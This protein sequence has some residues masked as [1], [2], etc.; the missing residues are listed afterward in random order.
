MVITR[1]DLRAVATAVATVAAIAVATVAAIAVAAV[2]AA[3]LLGCSGEQPRTEV[4][5]PDPVVQPARPA[6]LRLVVMIVVDQLPSWSFDNEQRLLTGG[7]RRLIDEGVYFPRAE[8]PYVITFTAPGH[9]ALGTGAPPSQTGILANGWF[10]PEEGKIVAATADEN[11]PVFRLAGEPPKDGAPPA[12]ES[13]AQLE[14]DG[15]ADALRAGGS[16]GRSVSI[17]LKSRAAIFALGRKPDLA[18]WYDADQPAMTSSRYYADEPP[19]WLVQLAEKHPVSDELDYVWRPKNLVTLGWTTMAPDDQRGEGGDYG[20]GITFPHDIAASENPARALKNTPLGDRLVFETALA[21]IEGEGL[22]DDDIPDLLSISFSAHDYA[23]HS[24]GHESWERL[25]L[26]FR[27]DDTIGE[28]LDYHD[29]QVGRDSYAVVLTGDH[30]ATRLVE[31]TLQSGRFAKRIQN[32]EVKAAAEAAAVTVLGRSAEPWV[33]AVTGSTAYMSPA[34]LALPEA[35]KLAALD[36]I[37]AAMKTVEGISYAARTDLIAGDCDSRP[38]DD[39]FACYSVMPA[40][41]GQ[42]FFA[43]GPDCV[44]T[45]DY[46]SGTSHGSA[47]DDDRIVPI[48]VFAPNLPARRANGQVSALQVAPTIA[49]LLGIAPLSAAKMPPL[50]VR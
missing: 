46:G 28:L 26:L 42:V 39:R 44:L 30:G 1:Y 24:W 6:T 22:G 7:F 48:I 17:A 3:A 21:A 14:V 4:R 38:P 43:P 13:A 41:S 8:F 25:D 23:G 49:E 36:A 35:R 20:M 50:P 29:E 37:V 2:A 45:T 12:G 31:R 27:L 10:R 5:D 18:V 11:S 9:A 19:G 40:R 34:L 15:L 32:D 16:G 47:N 33:G